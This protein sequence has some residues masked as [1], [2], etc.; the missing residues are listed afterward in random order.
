MPEIQLFP[1]YFAALNLC[2]LARWPHRT[3][4]Q[5][6]GVTQTGQRHTRVLVQGP[7]RQVSSKWAGGAGTTSVRGACR[8]PRPPVA[9]SPQASGA[10]STGA[11]T[12]P[13]AP[14]P[15]RSQLPRG[16]VHTLW[17]PPH[18]PRLLSEAVVWRLHCRGGR[19]GSGPAYLRPR[20]GGEETVI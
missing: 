8:G 12:A 11:G 14:C 20:G 3:W 5:Q 4:E 6:S 17:T 7:N 1:I 19:R 9:S 2:C 16:L 13:G 15:F 18:R 10:Q